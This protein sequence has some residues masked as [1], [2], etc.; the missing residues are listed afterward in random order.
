MAM[1]VRVGVQPTMLLWARSR[2]SLTVA[3]L[4]HR[5]PKLEEWER[6]DRQPTLNQ[7]EDFANATHTPIGML[8]LAEPPE[9]FI[10][11]PD[12]RTIG[13]HGV[14][15]PTPDLLDTVFL[16]QQRQEWYR[17]FARTNGVESLPFVGSLSVSSDIVESADL[18]REVLTFGVEERRRISSWSEA[19]RTLSEHSEVLGVLVMVSGVVGSNTHRVLDPD[20]FRGFALVDQLAPVIFINGTDTKAAQ[21]FTLAHE[22]AHVWLGETALSN[23]TITSTAGNAVERWCNQVAAELLVPVAAMQDEY[24]PTVD[25]ETELDRLARIFKVS[26]LVILRRIRDAGGHLPGR[27]SDLYSTELERVLSF[28]PA[29]SGG[30][31]YNTQPVR[32]SKRFARAVI[33]SALEGQ[34]LYRDAYRLLGFKKHATFTEFSHSLGID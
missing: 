23:V 27:F 12:F 33:V 25:F 17:D 10:P 32:V 14:S 15:R 19:F 4:A 11:I 34:T 22:L 3:D 7:L 29:G 5:F 18:M 30:N 31:F 20:E 16:C 21:I 2:S 24:R 9:E 26:T 1:T 28:R 13:D 6:G 8:F